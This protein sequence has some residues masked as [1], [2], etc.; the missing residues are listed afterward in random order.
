MLAATLV[1]VVVLIVAARSD[2]SPNSAFRA[3][4]TAPVVSVSR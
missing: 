2:A 4:G 1:A 3:H